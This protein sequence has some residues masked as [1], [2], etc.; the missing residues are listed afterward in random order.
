MPNSVM[1]YLQSD[2]IRLQ[3]NNLNNCTV[4]GC[5]TPR[6]PLFIDLYGISGTLFLA[7][8]LVMLR[9]NKGTTI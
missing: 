9:D 5:V 3:G 2:H 4:V 8:L 6:V 7:G 1:V